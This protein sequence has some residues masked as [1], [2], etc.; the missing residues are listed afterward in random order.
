MS[1]NYD[2]TIII[3]CFNE[4]NNIEALTAELNRSLSMMN[5]VKCEVIFVD[6]GSVDGTFERLKQAQHKGYSSKIIRFSR[7]F[8]SHAA[9]SA[10]I[11]ASQGLYTTH[12]AADLQYSPDVISRL[13]QKCLEGYDLVRLER[14]SSGDP[15]LKRMGSKMYAA[16][17]RTYVCPNYPPNGFDVIMFH[18][19]VR[20]QIKN[21]VEAN[22]SILIRLISM[23]F[24]QTGIF[25]VKVK[26]ERGKSKWTWQKNIKLLIDSFVSFSYIPIRC[27]SL[28]GLVFLVFGILYLIKVLFVGET[29]VQQII[30]VVLLMGFGVTNMALGI[31]GEYVWRTFDAV[32]PNKA[33]VIDSTIELS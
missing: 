22:T 26:R 2:I 11:H 3:P 6:D 24:K 19:K 16:L 20:N 31:L 7:N 27:I 30:L 14:E 13:Y 15:F 23:G 29:S 5:N 32:S 21:H 33:F 28:A 4:E 10:G 1:T 25:G 8:G 9:M 18:E 17:I 12:L